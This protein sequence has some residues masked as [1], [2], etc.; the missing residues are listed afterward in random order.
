[1]G[2]LLDYSPLLKKLMKNLTKNSLIGNN[3]S[4]LSKWNPNNF[5]KLSDYQTWLQDKNFTNETIKN[6]LGTINQY[7]DR[8]INTNAITNFFR[9]NLNKYEPATLRSK[10]NALASYSKFLRI[11]VDWERITKIIP[12]AQ[13]QLFP[14]IDYGDL[15]KLKNANTHTDQKTNQRNNLILDFLFYTGLRVS[16]LINIH[17]SDFTNR[18]LRIHGKGNKVRFVLLPE[19]LTKHFNPCSKSYLF[20]TRNNKKLTKGQIRRNI[21]RK[22]KQAGIKKVISPHTFRKSFAT[23]L[24]NRKGRLDTIQKQ[25]GHSSLD[26]TLGYIHNDYQT[27]YT[28]YSK[29]WKVKNVNY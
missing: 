15:E 5:N 7:G 24:Y 22:A 6:Y 1:M 19:F 3:T 14:T 10:R 12:S 13:R 9:E 18:L 4:K 21:V 16:E 26:T 25:L 29:L 2:G 17:H 11:N 20:L 28:D 27:L 8:E 23:N